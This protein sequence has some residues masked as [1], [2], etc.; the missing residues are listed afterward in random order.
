MQV[1][2]FVNDIFFAKHH[3]SEKFVQE[4]EKIDEK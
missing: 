4:I 3:A 2:T 1:D